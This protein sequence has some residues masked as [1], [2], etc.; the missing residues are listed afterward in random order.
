MFMGISGLAVCKAAYLDL[1]VIY[2]KHIQF[3]PF[4]YIML[5]DQKLFLKSI[6]MLPG[7]QRYQAFEGA[8]HQVCAGDAAEEAAGGVAYLQ[9]IEN[10]EKILLQ[11]I[12]LVYKGKA[13]EHIAVYDLS[14]IVDLAAP[15]GGSD[16]AD[17]Q[18]SLV[19]A[20]L[21][22]LFVYIDDTVL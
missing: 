3:L 20:G 22:F 19:I 11:G 16:R 15:S 14:R 9:W 17:G 6:S 13:D 2:Q 5:I 1:P 8:G 4:P 18:R 12:A 7:R 10:I 21:L